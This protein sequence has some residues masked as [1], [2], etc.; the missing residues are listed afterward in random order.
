MLRVIHLHSNV[1]N[2]TT[3]F[4]KNVG[5]N[6]FPN[7]CSRKVTEEKHVAKILKQEKI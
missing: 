3:F 7:M 5:Q 2:F 1:H 4:W 6:V